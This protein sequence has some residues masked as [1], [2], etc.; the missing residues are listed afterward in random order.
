MYERVH[1]CQIKPI[2]MLYFVIVLCPIV[3]VEA[4]LGRGGGRG[5][6]KGGK[7]DMKP[8]AVYNL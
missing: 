7:A 4:I 2:I 3:A 6:G 1:N 5:R 8:C